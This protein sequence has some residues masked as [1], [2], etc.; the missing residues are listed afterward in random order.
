MTTGI[1]GTAQPGDNAGDFN[2]YAFLAQQLINRIAGATIVQ[3]LAVTNAGGASAVGFVDVQPL[4]N[5]LDGD[6]AAVAHGPLY[7]LPY[8]RIQGGAD[9]LILDPKVGDKGIAIFADRDISAVKSSGQQSNPGS[10]RTNDMSD[11]MYLGGIL[12]GIPTQY[13]RF[14]SAGIDIVSPTQIQLTAPSIRLVGPVVG[15][16]TI[17][18]PNV[19]GTTNVTFGGKSG[20]AH[21]HSGVT[22][23]LNNSGP[24][25]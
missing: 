22:T 5:Q 10:Y 2:A 9:A 4:V 15:T 7:N 19:V 23:G 3:V 12:N 18:A 13:V 8:L 21:V 1:Q 11:G 25:I 17:T 20:I 6:G 16:S 14:S 24:P